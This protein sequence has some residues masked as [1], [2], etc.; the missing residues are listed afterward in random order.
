[1]LVAPPPI[2]SL[3]V[4]V[5]PGR[6]Y[7]PLSFPGGLIFFSARKEDGSLNSSLSRDIRCWSPGWSGLLNDLKI[8]MI[9]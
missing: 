8:V 1:M 9:L 5:T 6:Y 7:Y 3:F 4:A 2:P